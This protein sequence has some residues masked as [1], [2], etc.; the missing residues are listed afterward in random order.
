MEKEKINAKRKS[1]FTDIFLNLIDGMTQQQVADK[2]GVSRQNVGLWIKG[3]T[4]PDIFTLPKIAEAFNVS[5]DYLLGR[6]GNIKS[7]D[8]NLIS[9]CEYTGLSEKAINKIT[10]VKNH[11]VLKELINS[12][13]CSFDIEW[14]E[15]ACNIRETTYVRFLASSICI[16][17]FMRNK[18]PEFDE[19]DCDSIFDSKEGCIEYHEFQRNFLKTFPPYFT[20]FNMDEYEE[21]KE[22]KLFEELRKRSIQE[23]DKHAFKYCEDFVEEMLDIYLDDTIKDKEKQIDAVISKFHYESIKRL[24]STTGESILDYYMKKIDRMQHQKAGD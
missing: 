21:F 12:L 9:A 2:V 24:R 5:T 23:F 22:N 3:A 7:P 10:A 1:P 17:A 11:A 6:S 14:L 4:V 18:Y 20:R 13:V 16:S 19:N 15:N 8:T